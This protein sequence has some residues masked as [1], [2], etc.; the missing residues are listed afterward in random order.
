[1]AKPVP[2][3]YHTLTPM[4]SIV[5]A[6]RAL[7]FYKEALGAQERFRMAAPDGKIAHAELQ[8]GD[9]IVMLG[10]ENP[11]QGCQAPTTLKGTPISFYLYVND[12]DAAFKR[13]TVA[14]CT[15]RMPVADM[16]WGDRFGEV[17]DPFGYRWGFATHKE[18]LTPEEMH[19]RGQA[20]FAQM[21]G[22]KK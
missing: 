18:D 22:A 1:M 7:D 13:A 2:D 4:L 20:A 10:E 6:A 14:G 21:S 8:I 9:S 5:G 17:E 11:A 3:G 12:A 16:F 15:V 19:K